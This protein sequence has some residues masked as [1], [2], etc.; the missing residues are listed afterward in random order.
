MTQKLLVA[1]TKSRKPCFM[2]MTGV[3]EFAGLSLALA[4]LISSPGF[5]RVVYFISTGYAFSISAMAVAAGWLYRDSLTGPACA[6]LALLLL[7]VLRLGTYLLR[8][9][10]SPQFAKELADV[11]SR[12]EKVPRSVRPF[13]WISVSM[14]YVLMFSPAACIVQALFAK[15]EL[16]VGWLFAGVA[17]MGGGLLMESVA[18]AQKNAYKRTNPHRFCDVGLYRLVRC[19][20]YLGEVLFWLGNLLAGISAYQAYWQWA[21]ALAGFVCITLIMMG[22]TKRLEAKQDE[23]YGNRDDYQQ[24]VKRVPVLFPFVPVYSLRNIRVY[25]E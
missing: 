17:V 2:V 25:L 7:Y 19:P 3:C 16:P 20:N 21:M 5:Y 23:R 13:I 1:K 24:Y 8:R 4:L 11:H 15:R 6:Q 12:A 10:L 22:S 18:D 14:L 9:E